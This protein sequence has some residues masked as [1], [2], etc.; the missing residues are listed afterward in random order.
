[1]AGSVVTPTLDGHRPLLV[2]L[3]SL[4]A[5]APQG[6]PPRRSTQGVDASRL[7]LLLAVLDR[8]AGLRLPSHDVYAMAS[9]GARVNDPG[10]DL[11]LALAIASSACNQPVPPDLVACGEV[12]LGGELR[13]VP[14]LARRL[15]EAARLGFRTAIVPAT[16]AAAAPMTGLTTLPA[17]T[18]RDALAAAGVERR[19]PVTAVANNR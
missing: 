10:A 12:G 9:A 16:G 19:R 6:V 8:R 15:A 4:V 1:V 13:Q 14:Q 2:E 17:A 11:A 7:A 18:L 3:Q 5:R